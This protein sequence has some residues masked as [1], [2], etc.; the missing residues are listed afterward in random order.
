MKDSRFDVIESDKCGAKAKANALSVRA[1]SRK[2]GDQ[3]IAA[4]AQNDVGCFLTNEE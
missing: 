1:Y 3:A 2:D 4:A